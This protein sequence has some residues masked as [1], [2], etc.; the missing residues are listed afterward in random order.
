MAKILI[1]E[2]ATVTFRE[3]KNVFCLKKRIKKVKLEFPKCE[4]NNYLLQ[5][6][7]FCFHNIFRKRQ[8]DPVVIER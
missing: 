7:V 4:G 6:I 2:K 8:P 3:M 5:D 1:F